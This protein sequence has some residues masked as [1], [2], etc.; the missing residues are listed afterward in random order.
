MYLTPYRLGRKWP[1]FS[2]HAKKKKMLNLQ[3]G[4]FRIRKLGRVWRILWSWL[5][6]IKALILAALSS[7]HSRRLCLS[8]KD[9]GMK[10]VSRSSSLQLFSQPPSCLCSFVLPSHFLP[11]H[12]KYTTLLPPPP[13][14]T[15]TVSPIRE[16][17]FPTYCHWPTLR[18][19]LGKNVRSHHFHVQ[20]DCSLRNFERMP[21][22]IWKSECSGFMIV[23][24]RSD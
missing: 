16:H 19:G 5:C 20:M 24:M 11:L 8:D 2:S 4:V 7:W 3:A 10:L 17:S 21:S 18:K 1:I 9:T 23:D 22:A 6:K 14:T 15:S 12:V 13:P